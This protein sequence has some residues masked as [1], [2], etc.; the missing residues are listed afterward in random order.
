M[1]KLIL[2]KMNNEVFFMLT[3]GT[4]LYCVTNVSY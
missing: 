4:V 3:N 1:L 2:I